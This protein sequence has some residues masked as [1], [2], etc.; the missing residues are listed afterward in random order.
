MTLEDAFARADIANK[1]AAEL[2]I[3]TRYT[4]APKPE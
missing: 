4:V 1:Q 3:V 2:G